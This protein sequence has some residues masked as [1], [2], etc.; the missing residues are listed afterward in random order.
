MYYLNYLQ[1]LSLL[2]RSP[3]VTK[4]YEIVTITYINIAD[5]FFNHD[6]RFKRRLGTS[7]TL[8]SNLYMDSMV[9]TSVPRCRPTNLFDRSNAFNPL[10][11]R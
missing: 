4:K 7:R 1:P 9:D 5:G 3:P 10:P 11:I 8:N 6:G 2:V